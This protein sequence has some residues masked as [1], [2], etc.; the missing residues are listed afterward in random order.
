MFVFSFE[1]LSLLT[2]R[3]EFEVVCAHAKLSQDLFFRTHKGY[4]IAEVFQLPEHFSLE[5]LSFLSY[6]RGQL[7]DCFLRL[8]TKV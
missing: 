2:V 5:A 6:Q 8:C 3:H 4:H 7:F 1:S